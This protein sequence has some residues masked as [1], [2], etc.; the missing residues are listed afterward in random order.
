MLPTMAAQMYQPG[1][2]PDP[3]G[4]FEFRFHN[5]SLWTAD[6]STNGQRYVDPLGA[7]PSTPRPTLSGQ[8]VVRNGLALASMILGIVAVSIAWMPFVVVVG[9][10]CAVLAVIFGVI[11]LVRARRTAQGTGFAI[12]GLVTGLLASA[13]CV[14]GVIFSFAVVRAV[15]RFDNPAA[16]RVTV[17]SCELDGT[18]ATVVGEIE[19]LDDVDADFTVRIAFTRPG[20]DNTHRS[21]RAFVDDVAPGESATFELTRQVDLDAIDCVVTD[22]TGPLP[23]GLEIET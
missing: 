15:D 4:R 12:A 21:G 5:G 20:T 16:N 14:V 22:V 1:W 6:V 7:S 9:A 11:G 3:S 19:N 2:Y 10:V 18:T 23:F 8:P 13:L 17:S